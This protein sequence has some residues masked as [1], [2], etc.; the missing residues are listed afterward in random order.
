MRSDRSNKALAFFTK[1][2]YLAHLNILTIFLSMPIFTAYP[3]ICTMNIM[4]LPQRLEDAEARVGKTYWR[5]FRTIIKQ[6]WKIL[7][8]VPVLTLIIAANFYICVFLVPRGSVFWYAGIG[9]YS[10]LL[11]ILIGTAEY[12]SVSMMLFQ[13]SQKQLVYNAFF[14][15]LKSIPQI[16]LIIILRISPIC[17]LLLNTH[18]SVRLLPILLFF[19]ISV[20]AIMSCKIMHRQLCLNYPDLE[21]PPL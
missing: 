17:I 21:I 12:L 11:I 6:Y 19:G 18:I 7:L 16:L 3:A 8:V 13:G 9:I 14:L 4:L 10:T 2:A 15:C 5:V 20:P 1:F